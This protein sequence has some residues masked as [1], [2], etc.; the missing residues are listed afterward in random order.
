[1]T[2]ELLFAGNK[3]VFDGILSCMIS[4]FL[5]SDLSEPFRIHIFTMDACHLNP[6]YEALTETQRQFLEEVAKE[7]HYDNEVILYDL[8]KL[9]REF[10]DGCP[11]ENCYCSPYTLLRLFADL[12]DELPD[13]ILYLDADILFNAE[14][15]K[16]YDIDISDY[17][18]AAARDHYGSFFIHA[19]YINAG[20]LLLNLE[21]IRENGMLERARFLVRHK[22][23]PFADQSAIY[24]S[25]DKVKIISGKFN[26]QHCL[27][28]DTVVRHFSRR[29]YYLPYPHTE[30]IKQWNVRRMYRV[31]NYGQFEDVIE[32]YLYRKGQY[33]RI[34]QKES[35][36]KNHSSKNDE[37]LQ[38]NS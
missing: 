4:V 31:L 8:T 21:R 33:K 22:K 1:M 26:S 29:L 25:S 6:D 3:A 37:M 18:F 34:I 36:Q 16:L 19:N 14:I 10:F 24:R 12:V 9:Y 38:T 23:L 7:Y 28:E 27:K 17:E 5:R 32:E 35:Q 2:R 20:V 13:K 15:R 11:N 30:N